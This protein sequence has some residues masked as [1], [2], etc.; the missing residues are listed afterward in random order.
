M[1]NTIR[2][3]HAKSLGLKR[4]F[5]GKFCKRG[6]ISERW[7]STGKCTRCYAPKTESLRA[8]SMRL[9]RSALLA[10]KATYDPEALCANGHSSERY[11]VSGNCV[12]CSIINKSVHKIKPAARKKAIEY[13]KSYRAKNLEAVK[14]RRKRWEDRNKQKC[15]EY[16]SNRKAKLRGGIG[17][18]TRAEVRLLF[19]KQKSKCAFCFT[20]IAMDTLHRDHIVPLARGGSNWIANIQLLCA[21]CN[22]RKSA[23]DP[24]QFAQE[25]GRLL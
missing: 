3:R 5:T 20:P 19:A 12:E 8:K 4:Y 17:T 16:R 21:N 9:K 22:H 10:G 25:N 7:T 14:Q 13:S 23:K 18:F 2:R 6:H 1:Q 15:K 11:T 24:I